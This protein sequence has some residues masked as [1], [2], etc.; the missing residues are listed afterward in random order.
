VGAT[1]LISAVACASVL[2]LVPAAAGAAGDLTVTVQQLRVSPATIVRGKPVSF[3]VSYT[4]RGPNTRRAQATVNL[5]LTGTRNR[6]QVASRPA[7]VRPAIWKWSV[8]D[9][10]PSALSAG[11]YNVVATVTLKRGNTRIWRADK[12]MTVTV[13]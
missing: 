7:T 9:S 5:Q 8:T 6:Y 13:R 12:K 2:A 10:L 3:A 4:V 11:T 1:R